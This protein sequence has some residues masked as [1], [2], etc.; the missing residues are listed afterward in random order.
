MKNVAPAIVLYT[1]EEVY[2]ER[3]GA[4]KNLENRG[5]SASEIEPGTVRETQNRAWAAMFA[6]QNAKIEREAH[7]FFFC[8]RERASRSEKSASETAK[9]AES[10]ENSGTRYVNIDKD[11]CMY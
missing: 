2:T 8:G 7:R 1:S 10:P 9:S 3:A 6:R 4:T 5:V 11:V